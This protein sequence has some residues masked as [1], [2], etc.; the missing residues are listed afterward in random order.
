MV[1]A[2]RR[3]ETDRTG[4]H[5]LA[6][7]RAHRGDVLLGGG[8]QAHRALAHHIDPERAMR[9]LRANVHVARPLVD[10]IEVFA[11]AFPGP[12]QALLEHRAGN[13][14]DAFHQLDQAVAIAGAHGRKAHAAIAHDRGGHAMP[15]RGLQAAVPHRLRVVVRVHIDEARSDQL[16]ARVDF[17]AARAQGGADRAD[18]SAVDGDVGFAKGRAGAVGHRAASNDQIMF[19]HCLIPL[20]RRCGGSAACV[21]RRPACARRPER[22]RGR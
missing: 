20:S 3:G 2:A 14:L 11:K 1:D 12:V 17:I 13:V 15:A 16:A 6:G 10:R 21:P 4:L 9:Q 18:A 8:F 22:L 19:A 5:R 7:Q